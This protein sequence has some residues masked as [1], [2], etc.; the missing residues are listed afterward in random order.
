MRPNRHGW[1][2]LCSIASDDS[3]YCIDVFR[4]RDEYGF[5]SFRSDPEDQGQWTLIDQSA[6][7]FSDLSDTVGAALIDVHWLAAYP[8]AGA[9]LKQWLEYTDKK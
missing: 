9:A 2:V 4:C 1:I 6:T 3:V 5:A 7:R 8:K